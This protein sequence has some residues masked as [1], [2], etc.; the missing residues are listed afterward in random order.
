MLCAAVVIG[1]LRVKVHAEPSV[2]E[3][4][5]NLYK[6]SWFVNQDDCHASIR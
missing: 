4:I 6:W 2:K 5:E 1:A 3:G